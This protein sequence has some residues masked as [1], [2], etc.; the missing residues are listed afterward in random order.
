MH[1]A[2]RHTCMALLLVLLVLATDCCGGRRPQHSLHKSELPTPF[3]SDESK[4]NCL[5]TI[6]KWN[7]N[8]NTHMNKYS[9]KTCWGVFVFCDSSAS[10]RS[11]AI[12]ETHKIKTI[13]SFWATLCK[14]KSAKMVASAGRRAADGPESRFNIP[15]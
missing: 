11:Y 5:Y 12:Y 8:L 14:A 6:T 9:K 7:T 2:R 15:R 3:Q 4:Q 13:V 1:G 10:R